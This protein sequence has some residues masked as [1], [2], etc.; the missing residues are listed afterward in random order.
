MTWPRNSTLRGVL[1]R[2]MAVF[3]EAAKKWIDELRS[4]G[5]LKGQKEAALKQ[6]A[7]D[8]AGRLE[9]IFNEE[10]AKQLEIYGKIEEFKR[11]VLYDG[12]YMNKYLNQTIPGYSGFKMDVFNKAKK[13]IVDDGSRHSSLEGDF[14]GKERQRE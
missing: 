7:V 14:P 6:L 3:D 10:V 13:I 1:L 9:K 8:Y 11:M 4:K 2:V 12:Q 5:K